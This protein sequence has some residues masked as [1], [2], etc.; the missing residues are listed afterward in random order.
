M[1]TRATTVGRIILLNGPPGSGKDTIGRLL[2]EAGVGK[3]KSFKTQI[4]DIA[5]QVSNIFRTEWNTRYENRE[6]KEAS[7]DKLGGLSQREY[8]IKIS[9]EW[10]KPVHGNDYFGCA[11]V[12][13]CGQPGDYIFTDSGFSLEVAPFVDTGFEVVIFRLHREGFT[14]EG[15]SRDYL[16]DIPRTD[17][18]DIELTDGKPEYAV[19]LIKQLLL[20]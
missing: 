7:W 10:V 19:D 3:L 20:I 16:P 1:D 6:L 18:W 5:L 2:S 9:E 15:D 14:F 4:I 12:A 8:L 11:A 17:A 13:Q